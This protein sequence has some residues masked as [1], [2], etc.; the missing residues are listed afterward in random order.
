MDISIVLAC[1]NSNIETLSKTISSVLNQ[2]FKKFELIIVD[3]G[4][5]IPISDQIFEFIDPRV[6]MYRLENSGGL[7]AAL[8]YGISKANGKYIARIDDDDLM[9]SN[10]LELQYNYLEKNPSVVCVGTRLYLKV[11]NRII[12]YRKF[13]LYNDG[14][15]K[16]LINIRFSLAHTTVMYRRQSAIEM[17]CYRISGGGQDLDLF[18]QLSTIGELANLEEYLSVYSLSYSGLSVR[19]PKKKYKAYEFALNEFLKC[20]K[21]SFF[22][23]EIENTL[24]RLNRSSFIGKIKMHLTRHLLIIYVV[25]FGKSKNILK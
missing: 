1:H 23:E 3:D 12:K 9:I 16:D 10:R 5:V 6:R 24:L 11:G 18:L 19:F 15:L 8:N 4:S 7:G 17:G 21:S 20:N 14:I 25:I 22:K 2:T 13:P